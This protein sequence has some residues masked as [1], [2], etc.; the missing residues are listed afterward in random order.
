MNGL[1]PFF[2]MFFGIPA[3]LINLTQFCQLGF[4]RMAVTKVSGYCFA[5]LFFIGTQHRLHSANLLQALLHR[6]VRFGCI[7]C[8]DFIKLDGKA[9][10]RR[11]ILV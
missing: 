1:E 9:I 4:H 5:E 11:R 2:E 6:G 8:A 3:G 10:H 7:R